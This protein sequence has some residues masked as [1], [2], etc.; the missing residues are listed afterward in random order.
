MLSDLDILAKSCPYDPG[1]IRPRDF[2]FKP[3]IFDREKAEKKEAKKAKKDEQDKDEPQD[4][5][6]K[7]PHR[8]KLS[9]F[10]R[11]V[12]HRPG[13]LQIAQAKMFVDRSP[14]EFRTM[15]MQKIILP[16]SKQGQPF[17]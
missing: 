15:P 4:H 17:V 1:E 13:G 5:K 3:H 12:G 14:I 9:A 7:L 10:S 8:L 16:C 11:S 6:P 2:D